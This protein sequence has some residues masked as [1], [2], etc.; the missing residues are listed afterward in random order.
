MTTAQK[1]KVLGLGG[2][3][4]RAHN[5]AA[6]AAWYREHLGFEVQD[7]GGSFGAIFPFAERETGYQLWTAFPADTPYL[8]GAAQAQML[9][10]RVADLDGLLAQLRAA[11][12]SVEED[13]ERSE[14]GAFGWCRD[15]EG[16]R[17]E[18]WQPPTE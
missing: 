13:I 11:G 17:V 2:V 18:L 10:F 8:G 6:L 3:F 9:N 4:I 5:P 15:G 16:N 7:F 14:Y 12:V 1:H